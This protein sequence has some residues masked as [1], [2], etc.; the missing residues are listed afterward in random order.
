[1]LALGGFFCILI[2]CAIS[3]NGARQWVLRLVR[4]PIT[5]MVGSTLAGLFLCEIISLAVETAQQR[6]SQAQGEQTR[7]ELKNVLQP[8]ADAKLELRLP[9]YAGG[10]D[11]KGFRNDTV[12]EKVDIVA[13]GDSQ[14]WGVNATRSE[15]WPQT[16]SRISGRT[17][18]NMG[19]GS[20]G[21]VH[22]WAMTDEALTLSPKIVVVAIFFGNDLWDAYRMVYTPGLYP[23]FRATPLNDE[24]LHDTIG[25]RYLATVKEAEDF[26]AHFQKPPSSS[27]WYDSLRAH[28][29]FARVFYRKGIWPD[30]GRREYEAFQRNKAWAAAYPDKGTVYEKGDTR[31]VFMTGQH[32]LGLD[33]DNPRIAE[34]LRITKDMLLRIQA[35]TAQANAKLLVLFIPTKEMVYLHAMQRMN[36]TLNSSYEKVVQMESRARDEIASS[37]KQHGIEYVDPLTTLQGAIDRNEQIYPWT[38]DSHYIPNGYALLA[39]E[40]NKSIAKLKW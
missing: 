10:H 30:S 32:L 36:G 9:P 4:S 6:Q 12:P 33:L 15:A 23:Q 18:Y 19:L 20:Y 37:N 13:I 7:N 3:Q 14:T 28:S 22:Y 8:V 34:G 40:V 35:K 24:L 27:T 5:L 2:A 38:G 26:N 21:T 16:L 31:T 17:V 39:S 25:A 29:A 1:M 11:A